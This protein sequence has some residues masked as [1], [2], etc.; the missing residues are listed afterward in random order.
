MPEIS[1][2]NLLSAIFTS[3]IIISL[4]SPDICH[5]RCSP[6]FHHLPTNFA[7][8]YWYPHKNA[9]DSNGILNVAFSFCAA[10]HNFP[11]GRTMYSISSH[12]LRLSLGHFQ[13]TFEMF[14]HKV[15]IM[16][17]KWNNSPLKFHFIDTFDLFDVN[18]RP[19]KWLSCHLDLLWSI[20]ACLYMKQPID[21]THTARY[22]HKK[23]II[24]RLRTKLINNNYV[25]YLAIPPPSHWWLSFGVLRVSLRIFH[26]ILQIIYGKWV[27]N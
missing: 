15:K 11:F 14:C 19:L 27:N 22:T 21:G 18:N 4:S 8:F 7:A 13:F 26:S 20:T 1:S 5:L 17:P 24:I 9:H 16:S 12:L 25:K 2:A 23:T 3:I 10:T 6:I